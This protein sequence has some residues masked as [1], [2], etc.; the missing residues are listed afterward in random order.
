MEFLEGFERRDG[1]LVGRVA[2]P[3]GYEYVT[4]LGQLSRTGLPQE[5]PQWRGHRLV[6]AINDLELASPGEYGAGLGL[7]VTTS[8]CLH[9]VFIY[10]LPRLTLLIPALALL[11]GLFP[12]V[13]QAFNTLFSPRGLAE[14]CVPR[15]KNGHWSVNVTTHQYLPKAS[16]FPLSMRQ[17]LTWAW[18]FRSGDQAWHSVY[19]NAL[20]GR[21][22][23]ALPAIRVNAGMHGIRKH[24]TVYVTNVNIAAL[25]ACDAPFDFAANAPRSFVLHQRSQSL[26][27]L[28]ND[29][30]K[31]LTTRYS[32]DPAVLLSDQEWIVVADIFERRPVR[33]NRP[34]ITRHPRAS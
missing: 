16:L 13:P 17:T 2:T 33:M 4:D 1:R 22:R 21:V 12:L 6:F 10:R 29:H 8:A 9:D 3:T 31:V 11:R 14:M 7:G 19:P 20:E 30:N 34:G 26:H 32:I 27:G 24:N 28:A 5:R 23:F 18:L 15:E 25:L